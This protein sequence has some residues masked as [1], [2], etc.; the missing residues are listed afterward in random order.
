MFESVEIKTVKEAIG[1]LTRTMRKNR[2]LTQEELAQSTDL[3]ITTI[4]KLEK[5][6]NFTIE[7]LLKVLKELDLLELL[8]SE[9]TQAQAQ[10]NNVKSLY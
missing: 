6:Q 2:R 9:I 10:V 3:S 5:G 8:N 4:K 7:T 1:G